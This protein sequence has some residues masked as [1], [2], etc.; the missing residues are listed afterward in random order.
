M[1]RF[2]LARNLFKPR[3]QAYA[4]A[5]YNPSSSSL[6][7]TQ[8][9]SAQIGF[10]SLP[11]GSTDFIFSRNG[12][13]RIEAMSVRVAQAFASGTNAATVAVQLFGKPS[14]PAFGVGTLSLGSRLALNN[15]LVGVGL[16]GDI[17]GGIVNAPAAVANQAF[18]GTLTLA[19]S[20]GSLRITVAVEALTAGIFQ[21]DCIYTPL[22]IGATL[23]LT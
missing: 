8:K 5:L 16:G 11:V 19:G 12:D 17:G 9:L 23:T 14:S 13:I 20:S 10:A 15:G 3:K 22:T 18:G 1:T 7:G 4:M 6:I 21:I 2:T